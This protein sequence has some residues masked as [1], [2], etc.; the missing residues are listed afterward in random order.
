MKYE[1]SAFQNTHTFFDY[2]ANLQ[3]GTAMHTEAI[4]LRIRDADR[5]R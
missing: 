4:N 1:L 5:V 2:E 3:L